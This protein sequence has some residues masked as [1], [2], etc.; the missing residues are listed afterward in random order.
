MNAGMQNAAQQPG[1][2]ILGNNNMP[3]LFGPQQNVLQPPQALVASLNDPAP[4]GNASIFHGLPPPP[5]FNPG[6]I[7]TPISG[8]LKTRKPAVLPQYKLN[9]SMS[10]RL[11]TPQKSGFGFSYTTYGTPSSAS[12]ISSTPGA[13]RSSLLGSSIGR[14]LGKSF[15]TSNLRRTF[16]AD[17]DSILAPG[18]FSASGS[19]FSGSGS[20]KR[21]TIDRSLRTDLFNTSA[22]PGLPSS[23]KN[24]LARSPSILKKKVSFD[25]TTVGG[26]GNV[27]N[28]GSLSNGSVDE[29]PTPSAKE[30]GYLRS[31]SSS[32]LNGRANGSIFGASQAQS[33]MT[34][35][36]G[37]ELAIVHE[38]ESPETSKPRTTNRAPQDHSD[39]QPGRYWI[40]PSMSELKKMSRDQLK[41]L[42]GVEI[43]RENCGFCAFDEPVDMTTVDL[44]K[45]FGV[46]AQITVRSLTIYP[47]DV[48]KPPVGKGLNVP[49]TITLANSWPRQRDKKTPSYETTGTRYNK[50]IDRLSKVI[51]TD[52][53][54]YDKDTGEWIFRVPHFTTYA[55]DYDD[56]DDQSV[57]DGMQS[58]VLSEVPPTLQLSTPEVRPGHIFPHS[59][60]QEDSIF[61]EDETQGSSEPEDTFEY[62]TKRSFPGAFDD[63]PTFDNDQEMEEA[64]Q[65]GQSFLDER[66]VVSVSD[67]EDEPSEQAQLDVAEDKSLVVQDEDVEMIGAFPTVDNP[68]EMFP[69]SILKASRFEDNGPGTPQRSGL[70]LGD[71]WTEQLQRTISPRKQDRRLLRESQALLFRVQDFDPPKT[72]GNPNSKKDGE[73]IATSIDLMNSL[74]GK[75]EARK[76]VVGTR[77]QN[78]SSKGFQV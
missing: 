64:K 42:S 15:S 49:S 17:S 68:P 4:Y 63:L 14:S 2:S 48:K 3:S 37:N 34:Q 23:D 32:R 22:I 53:V 69:K 57:V 44:D 60:V 35:V 33:E 11:I 75:E 13:F 62:K 21:L 31:S 73:E 50:H 72:Q 71:D 39:P 24:E 18:A 59:A 56:D 41:K 6:P 28:A 54:R 40:K 36:K 38:D 46:I 20:L 12:S 67:D 26:N 5:Q 29:S 25:A 66:S 47:K 58:S 55:L 1:G 19:R 52:F 76:S 65:N 30:Q 43:G 78:G 9:P 61:T 7:A 51:N 10:S 70:N 27:S 16:D 45:I 77:K 74:F 8:G